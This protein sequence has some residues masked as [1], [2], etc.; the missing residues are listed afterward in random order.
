MTPM[1]DRKLLTLGLGGSVLAALCCFTPL[2]VWALG[3][4][5]LGALIAGLD[6]VLWP[7]LL[8]FAGLTV[9][10]LFRKSRQAAARAD[11]R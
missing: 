10:A 6:D 2:L 11:S 9:Y 1:T 7:T 5:G 8:L 3:A 4:L